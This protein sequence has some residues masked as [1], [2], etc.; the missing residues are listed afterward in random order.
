MSICA[1]ITTEYPYYSGEPFCK[2]EIQYLAQYFDEVYIFSLTGRKKIS[3][4]DVPHNVKVVPLSCIRGVE[5][6]LVYSIVGILAINSHLNISYR[7]SIY[8]ILIEI[9]YRGRGTVVFNKI[10]RYLKKYNTNDAKMIFYSYWFTDQA[11]SAWRLK[12]YFGNRGINCRAVSRAHRYDLYWECNA[13]GYLPYQKEAIRYLDGVYTCSQ[14]GKTYLT[15]KYGELASNIHVARLGTEDFGVADYDYEE[16]VLVTCSSLIPLKRVDLF[17]RAF[18]LLLREVPE[19]QW[20]CIGDGPERECIESIIN[21]YGINK[22]VHFY[23]Q[24][25]NEAVAEIYASKN[26]SYFCNVSETEG[27]PVS[28]MEAMS[29]S[30]PCIATD[31]GGS[32]ELVNNDNGYLIPDNVTDKDLAI[33]LRDALTLQKSEY[34][35]KRDITRKTWEQ[36]ASAK[37]NYTKWVEIIK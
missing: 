27:V 23:G 6:Y 8:Q 34:V 11:Y 14:N 31:V 29:F 15:N 12:E 18:A 32:G 33:V 19:C 9:Y 28:I 36:L 7:S 37:D 17:A 25:K 24:I 20:I 10:R 16:K 4:R 26:V 30:I 1:L 2:N 5:R 21:D 13:T 3:Y 35:V 22:N